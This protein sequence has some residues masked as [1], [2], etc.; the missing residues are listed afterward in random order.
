MLLPTCGGG[1]FA[2]RLTIETGHGGGAARCRCVSYQNSLAA[3]SRECPFRAP[4]L[5]PDA[6]ERAEAR[7]EVVAVAG[8][9]GCWRAV[10]HRRR[11]WLVGLIGLLCFFRERSDA[12]AEPWTCG[13]QRIKRPSCRSLFPGASQ[14]KQAQSQTRRWQPHFSR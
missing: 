6:R 2:G 11:P 14:A 1:S 4:K 5:A 8:P 7:R 9:V 12:E 13:R 3:P 10:G